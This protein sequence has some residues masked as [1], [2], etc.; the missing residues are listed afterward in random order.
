MYSCAVSTGSSGQLVHRIPTHNK[1]WRPRDWRDA[2]S[3]LESEGGLTGDPSQLFNGGASD[4]VLLL[5]SVSYL[6][7][8]VSINVYQDMH[9]RER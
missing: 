5:H 8:S 9:T 3:Q 6:L 4:V 2:P 7:I 1:N